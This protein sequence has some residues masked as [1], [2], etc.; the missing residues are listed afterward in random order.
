M[1]DWKKELARDSI[2]LGST[3]FYFVVII[4]AI[5]GQYAIFV[6]QMLIALVLMVLLSRFFDG[7]MYVARCFVVWVF[8]SMFYSHWLYTVFAFFVWVLV[9]VSSYYLKTKKKVIIIGIVF[10]VVSALVAYYLAPLIG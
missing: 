1:K 3:L 9:I 10:G 8:T 6:Y 7:D 4:R 5:V 2:A